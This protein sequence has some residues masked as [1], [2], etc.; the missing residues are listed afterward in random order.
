MQF[1]DAVL[2]YVI[3]TLLALL[4]WVARGT[5]ESHRH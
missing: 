5:N 1:H 3:G 4:W 2:L